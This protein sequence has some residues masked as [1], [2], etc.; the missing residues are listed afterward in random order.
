MTELYTPFTKNYA[1]MLT[2]R[3]LLCPNPITIGFFTLN[4]HLA[5]GGKSNFAGEC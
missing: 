5:S 4:V 1:I 2:K 3:K